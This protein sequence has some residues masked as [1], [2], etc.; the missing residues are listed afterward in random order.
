MAHPVLH[1]MPKLCVPSGGGG[2]GRKNVGVSLLAKFIQG[3]CQTSSEGEGRV[4]QERVARLTSK[5]LV[6][7]MCRNT[8]ISSMPA[9]TL[10]ITKHLS[11]SPASL[12]VSSPKW[13][14]VG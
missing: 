14:M 9:W 10:H 13:T 4:E 7:S 1:P 3:G 5:K 6:R 12:G 2:G 11:T 8:S